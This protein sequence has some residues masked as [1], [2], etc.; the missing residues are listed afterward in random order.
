M[1]R[2]DTIIIGAG[3]AGLALSTCLTDAGRDHVVLERGRLAERWRSERWDS[4]RLLTPNWMSRLPGWSYRG[5]EPDAF[6]TVPELV[7]YFENYAASFTAPVQEETTVL[8]VRPTTPG[9]RVETDQGVWS[10]LNVVIAT[11]VEGHPYVPAMAAELPAGVHQVTST[12]YKNPNHL[13]DGAILVVGASAT[14]V[15]LADELARAGREVTLAVGDHTRMPR[16]YRGHDIFRW[17]EWIGSFDTTIDELPDPSAAARA[18]SMQLVGRPSNDQIDLA[19]LRERGVRLA[20]RLEHLEG[21]SA[22][23]RDDLQDTVSR[24]D[25]RMF[26]VLDRID[27]RL[28]RCGAPDAGAPSDRPAPLTV[29]SSPTTIDLR[30]GGISTVVWATGFRRSYPWLH[31]PVVGRDGEI[32]QRRGVTP[33]P[34]LYVLGL[35]FQYHRNSNFIDGVG[36]DAAYIAAHIGADAR[37]E[38]VAA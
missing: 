37:D 1:Q 9:Y 14:G 11:G 3:Q 18:P 24:S 25:Q 8:A 33:N 32:V 36:R 23:F 5:P 7:A 27:E 15:Q 10:A 38:E 31:V 21:G 16:R 26:R 19:T 34:G 13:P 4:L 17:L 22:G 35:R 28:R 20:G 29:G 2:T 12:T 30:A 6:M